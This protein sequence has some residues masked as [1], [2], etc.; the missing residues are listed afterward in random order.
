[1]IAA[2]PTLA[3]A[4]AALLLGGAVVRRERFSRVSLLFLLIPLAIAVWLTCF[5]VMFGASDYRS[6]LA[7]A[8]SA[9]LG[10]AFIPAAI[11]TFTVAATGAAH[12]RRWAT[13]ALWIVSSVA[14][15]LFLGSNAFLDGLYRF[16]WGYYPRF[17]R[18]GLAYVGF[19]VAA[20][21]ASL[22]EHW[23]DAR[24]A[25]TERHR[26]RSR[27]YLAAFFV[28]SLGSV[29]YL[30]AYGVHVYP[31]GFLPVLAF[32]AFTARTVRRHRLVDITPSLAAPQILAT[33]A[34]P[35]L[36]CDADDNVGLVN[37]ALCSL[38]GYEER[39]LVGRPVDSLVTA[40]GLKQALRG[41]PVRLEEVA[42]VRGSVEDERSISWLYTPQGATRAIGLFVMRQPGSNTIEV[43]DQI[44]KLLPMFNAMLPPAA[45]CDA[46]TGASMRSGLARMLATVRRA[47]PRKARCAW[48]SSRCTP[49]RSEL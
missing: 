15:A 11:Y 1:M 39:D 41:R 3:T 5:S 24:A 44:K 27:A 18:L 16:P 28:G 6:A 40:E 8:R 23:I 48:W 4:L 13:A 37:Q 19:F 33:M 7:W 30:P 20:L 17:T 29:D 14:A 35:L 47:S 25:D 22:Y 21:L 32:I 9:Y 45:V 43:I 12:R 42:N 2:V 36:V 38:L 49:L 26:A 10:I 34:D 31:I 46:M